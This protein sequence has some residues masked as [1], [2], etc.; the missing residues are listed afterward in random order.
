MS[1]L[2]LERGCRRLSVQGPAEAGTQHPCASAYSWRQF[3]PL[4]I[5]V[6]VLARSRMRYETISVPSHIAVRVLLQLDI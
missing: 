6:L 5:M 4:A 2:R 1:E 3:S